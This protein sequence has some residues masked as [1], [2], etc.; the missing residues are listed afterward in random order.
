MV[1]HAFCVLTAA[2]LFAALCL[3]Q[4]VPNKGD[5]FDQVTDKRILPAPTCEKNISFAWVSRTAEVVSEAPGFAEKWVRKHGKKHPSLCFDQ[6]PASGM[7]NYLLVFSASEAVFKGMYPVV[8]T[9]TTTNMNP[10]SGD[11]TATDSSGNIWSYTFDGSIT[12][13][14]TTTTRESLPYTDTSNTLYLR[15]YSQYGKLI[16]ERW[17]TFVNRRGGDDTD[18]AV[19]NAVSGLRGIHCKERLL[20]IVVQDIEK[21]SSLR[22]AP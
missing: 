17:Y 3:A 20:A 6:S 4:Q 13:T 22:D 9:T 15:S 12:T 16:S 14:A 8:K 21:H 11:G 2:S 7:P 19:F 5:I 18:T 1:R 10:I